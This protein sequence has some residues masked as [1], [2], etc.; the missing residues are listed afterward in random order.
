VSAGFFHFE[1]LG[2]C[3]KKIK[4]LQKK[5]ISLK[6]EK[7]LCFICL[8]KKMMKPLT[9][10]APRTAR[11]SRLLR[12]ANHLAREKVPGAPIGE[13]DKYV[14]AASHARRLEDKTLSE[15]E[16]RLRAKI[17]PLSMTNTSNQHLQKP[18]I[19]ND[20]DPETDWLNSERELSKRQHHEQDEQSSGTNDG[21]VSSFAAPGGMTEGS[22]N[23]FHFRDY[24]MF[25][26]E[27]VPAGHNTLASLRDELKADLTAQSLKDAWMRVT[28]GAFFD[29]PES[30]YGNVDG[31]DEEQLADVVTALFPKLGPH[32]SNAL[33]RRVLESIS[34]SSSAS[35][36]RL[37]S[38][39]TAEALGLDNAPGHYSNFLEWMGRMTGTKAFATEHAI[40]QFSRRKFNRNDVQHMWENYNLA[41]PDALAQDRSDGYSHFYTVLKDFAVKVAGRDTRHQKGVRIDPQEVDPETGFAFGEGF[42]DTFEVVCLIRENRE[43]TGEVFVQGRPLRETLGDK[44]WFMEHVLWPFDE[45]GVNARDF[46]VYFI[47]KSHQAVPDDNNHRLIKACRLGLSRA[48]SNLMPITRIRLKKA[49]LLTF[50]P[51]TVKGDHPGFLNQKEKR[52]KFFKR[53]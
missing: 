22:G 32:E 50:D 9:Q 35:A 36:R 5:K 4:I 34:K 40:F 31:L 6:L 37:A 23:L 46:D 28:G 19:Y 49:G 13:A 8:K 25:P 17:I 14:W 3:S 15:D 42:H 12:L 24:P 2:V 41:S 33:I 38:T 51:S 20:E 1:S 52:R 26:G 16:E 29:S 18:K 10:F 39:V 47:N 30:F 27:Y 43:A 21:G 11:Q 53:G 7:I 45:A 44:S 48:L